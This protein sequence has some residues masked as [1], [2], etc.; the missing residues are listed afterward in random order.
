[1]KHKEIDFGLTVK[2]T[3]KRDVDFVSMAKLK[4]DIDQLLTKKGY[5]GDWKMKLGKS[6]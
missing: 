3:S 4:D 6:Y 5:I 2:R 1:M